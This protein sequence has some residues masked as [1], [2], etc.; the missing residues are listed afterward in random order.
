MQHDSGSERATAQQLARLLDDYDLAPWF[1][2]AAVVVDDDVIPHSHPV[3]TLSTRHLRDDLLLLSTYVHEQSHWIVD[4]APGIDAAVAELEARFPD[5][6]V[7]YPDGASDHRSSYVHLGVNAF[8]YH[9][10]R[11]LA[12]ELRAQQVVQFW[13][14]D[15][16]RTLYRTVLDHSAEILAILK[17]H[18]IVPPRA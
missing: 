13:A 10:L 17:R 1:F 5:L 12:G 15:H 9:A 16:Y 4:G 11:R 18:G 2:T 14:T 6:P 3:L 8:E 7:G